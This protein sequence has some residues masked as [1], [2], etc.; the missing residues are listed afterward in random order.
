[1]N[2]RL[3]IAILLAHCAGAYAAPIPFS[4]NLGGAGEVPPNASPGTGTTVVTYDAAVHMLNVQIVFAALTG[5]TAA[6]HIHC[7][8]GTPGSGTAGV[9]TQ[10]PTFSSFPLGVT[11]GT[12]SMSFDL[13]MSASWNPTFVTGNG[14]TVATAEAAFASALTNGTAYLNIHSSTAPGGE[15]RGFLTSDVVFANG[16]E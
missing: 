15:I 6:S 13:T 14:G 3:L 16:Y 7:C 12:Y 10:L 5:T 8:V 9:A 1:M 11:S 4:A 2:T